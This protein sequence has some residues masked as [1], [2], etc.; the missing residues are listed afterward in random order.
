[1][2]PEILTIYVI[3]SPTDELMNLVVVHLMPTVCPTNST[4][5]KN[6]DILRG[7]AVNTDASTALAP[8]LLA[9]F[10][11]VAADLKQAYPAVSPGCC[12]VW[13]S[14]EWRHCNH[15]GSTSSEG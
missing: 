11:R 7:Q 3:H 13:E 9:S 14:E 8:V 6:S 15:D 2:L 5:Q 10:W 1:M 4:P 12:G